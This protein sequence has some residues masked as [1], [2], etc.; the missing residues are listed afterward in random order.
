[1]PSYTPEQSDALT[2]SLLTSDTLPLELLAFHLGG[3]DR[4][5]ASG[6]A[7]ARGLDPGSRQFPWGRIWRRIHGIEPARLPAHLADLKNRG[8]PGLDDIDDLERALRRPLL[9]FKGM[10]R[11]LGSKPDTLS[12]ALRQGRRA[13]P[14]PTVVLGERLRCYRPFEVELWRDHGTLLELPAPLDAARP[15]VATQTAPTGGA[16]AGPDARTEAGKAVFGPFAAN[17]R[18]AAA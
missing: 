13:L 16:A 5:T 7:R 8:V 1:M 10:A 2:A 12:K 4:A 11:A 18:K 3:L 9:D 6:I 17:K 15:A 14:V